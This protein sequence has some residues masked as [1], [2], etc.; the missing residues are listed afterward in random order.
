MFTIVM[1]KTHGLSLHP[2]YTPTDR[3]GKQLKNMIFLVVG[4]LLVASSGM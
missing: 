1:H 2:Q 4:L 3:L